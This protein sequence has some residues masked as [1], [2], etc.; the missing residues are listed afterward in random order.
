M[1]DISARSLDVKRKVL[2]RLMDQD[3]Y[4]Y[5]KEYLGSFDS[6][7]STI[8]LVGMN[9]ACLNA[10]WL[11]FDM[12]HK[13]AQ[14]FAK[15][16]MDFMREKLVEYQGKY[17]ALFN[18]EASPAESTSYR[19]A[20]HD[21]EK[22]PDI[23]CAGSEGDTPYYTNS[24]HLPVGFTDDMFEALQMQDDLQTK[25]TGGTMFHAFLGEK[26]D[27]WQ[28]SAMLVKKI[29]DNYKLP[30]YTISPTYSICP[31]HGYISGETY[32]CPDCGEAT[33]VY[34]RI[35]GYYR[36]VRNWNAGKSQE[37]KNRKEYVHGRMADTVAKAPEKTVAVKKEKVKVT[38]EKPQ[39]TLFTAPGCSKCAVAK[40]LL[41]D[42]ENLNIINVRENM[43]Q[44]EKYNIQAIPAVV[45]ENGQ[46]TVVL[47]DLESIRQMAN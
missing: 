39:I 12:T 31:S 35:T 32:T 41:K 21:R 28:T 43:D 19:L 25:Y 44:T 30:S 2:T 33:E 22:Y 14:N 17:N 24:T 15:N 11:G 16:I 9:E 47:R 23:V 34:S 7:F 36:P 38:Y 10:K 4:P 40:R 18:L 37:F 27:D 20:K 1:M 29:A 5:T 3:L 42:K 6:H 46:D 8:G 13:S 45:I 26:I